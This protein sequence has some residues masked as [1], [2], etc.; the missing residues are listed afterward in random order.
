MPPTT[1]RRYLALFCAAAWLPCI[2]AA[3]GVPGATSRPAATRPNILLV[4]VDDMSCDSIGAF[5]CKL[6]GTSPN[7]DRL[8]TEGVRF[9]YAHVH[10]GACAP[11]RREGSRRRAR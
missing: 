8:T 4:T 9:A 1:F 6:P 7:V 2:A 3:Q 11:S 10:T 5:G